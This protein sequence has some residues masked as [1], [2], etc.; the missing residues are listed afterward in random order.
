MSCSFSSTSN[1]LAA[2]FTDLTGNSSLQETAGFKT[3]SV[4][5]RSNWTSHLP[6]K[7]KVRQWGQGGKIK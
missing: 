6:S 1:L 4:G 3:F 5:Q 7:Y 2:D